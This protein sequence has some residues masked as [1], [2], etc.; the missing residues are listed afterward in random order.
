MAKT[1]KA[2]AAQARAVAEY[3][4]ILRAVLDERPSGTRQRLATALGK[5]RSFVSQIVNAQY[6]TPIPARHLELIFDICH[7]PPATRE[8]FMEAYARAH[9]V[10]LAHSHAGTRLRRHTV[11]LPDLGDPAR[12]EK[13]DELVA[14]FVRKLIKTLNE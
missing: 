11:L 6:P 13:I 10:R 7:F 5:N 2:T 9:P 14:D 12:N 8:Q 3:K 1:E 4:E